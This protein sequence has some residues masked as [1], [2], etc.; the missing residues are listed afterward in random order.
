M[1]STEPLESPLL[2]ASEFMSL[3]TEQL[4]LSRII[5]LSVDYFGV[6][7][8]DLRASYNDDLLRPGGTIAG[9]VMM[10]LADA[11]VYGAVLARLGPV[12]MAVTTHLS[13]DFLRKPGQAD[14]I[15][16][17]HLL[18]LGK[19]LAVGD[20]VLT[21]AAGGELVAKA[22]ATYSIPKSGSDHE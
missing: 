21:S 20:V 17:A 7:R 9:P 1:P 12:A 10:T 6:D 18:K 2:S 19:R 4:P 14:V 22:S 5:G 16:S 15:A 8:V 3:C 11:A 13:I